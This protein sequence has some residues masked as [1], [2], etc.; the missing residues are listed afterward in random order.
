ME[1]HRDKGR[2][3]LTVTKRFSGQKGVFLFS[4]LLIG[5]TL[6]V[7][8][9]ILYFL[10]PV[11][12]SSNYYQKSLKPLRKQAREIKNEFAS[13]ISGIEQKQ[14]S[15]STLSFPSKRNE[16]FD[17]LKK[18]NINSDREG[19]SYYDSEGKLT[20]WLGKVIDLET[21]SPEKDTLKLFQKEKSSFLIKDKASVYLVFP[22]EVNSK[23][24]IVFNRL[25]AFEPQFKTRYLREYQFLKPKIQKN[26]HSLLYY[27]Y[28]EDIS[29]FERFFARHKDEYIGQPALQD[30]TQTLFFPLRNEKKKIMALVT[31]GSPSLAS[32]V[33][34]QKENILLSFYILFGTTLIFFLLYLIKSTAFYKDIKFLPFL[35]FILTLISLRLT[36]LSMSRLETINSLSVFSPSLASFLSSAQLTKSPAD[37]FLTA[38]FL[39][40][41]ISCVVIYTKNALQLSRNKLPFFLSFLLNIILIFFSI[42]ISL[43]FLKILKLFIYNSNINL[44]RYTFSPAFILLHLSILFLFLSFI[45]II[46]MAFRMIS[47]RSS[48][49]FLT[50]PIFVL[51]F[52]SFILFFEEKYSLLIVLFQTIV[53]FFLLSYAFFPHVLKR[54]NVFVSAFLLGTLFLYISLHDYSSKRSKSLVQNT[55]KNMVTSQEDWG[56]FLVSQSIPEIEERKESILSFIKS[57]EPSDFAQSL[58]SETSIAKFNWYSSLEIWNSEEKMISRFSLNIPELYPFDFDLPINQEWSIFDLRS[59]FMGK[60]KYFLVGYK[61]WF[62]RETHLGRVILTLSVDYDMLPFLYP[63]N[64]YFELIRVTSLPSLTQLDLGFIIFD[65]DGKLLFNPHG[66]STGISPVLLERIRSSQDSIWSSFKDKNKKYNA[67]YFR[68]KDRIYSFFMPKKNFINYSVEFLKLLFIYIIFFIIS[69]LLINIILARKKLK[70]P[71][72]SFSNKVYTSFIAIAIISLLIFAFFTRNFLERI[73]AQQYIEKAETH[74]NFAYRVMEDFIF[75]HQP[76]KYTPVA[77]PEDL[78]LWISSTINNDVNLYKEGKVYASSRREFYD[79]GLLP[80]LIDGEIY[81]EIQFENNPFT[82]QIQKIGEYSLHTL[83]IPFF[84]LDSF[85]L[86][87]LPF[88]FEQQ[89]ISKATGGFFEFLVFISLFFIIIVLLFA[90][91]LGAIIITPI[92]K[93]LAG[94]KEVSLGNLEVSIEHKPQDEMRTLIDGFNTMIKNLKKHQQELTEMSKTVAWAEMARKVAHE[95]K[96]PLTPIQLSAE[97]LLKVY[98][99]KKGD[100]DKALKESASYI[101]KEVENLKKIAHEFL[102]ASK[103]EPLKVKPFDLREVI[104]ET[105]SPYEKMLLERIKFKETYEGQDFG[106]KGDKDKIR[107]ALRNIFINAIEAIRNKGE[108]EVK[109]K[110][111]PKNLILEIRDTGMGMEK[112]MLKKAFEPYFSTKDAGTGLG[113]SIAKKIID[114]HGGSIQIS[115]QLSKGTKVIIKFPLA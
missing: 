68:T 16:I 86:I 94:T 30:K 83:T 27:D 50:L 58:W 103:E 76:E 109:L 11:F 115:S 85:L 105:A 73:F 72:W 12:I 44:L 48:R 33:S 37:I 61:D 67:F 25:L 52:G 107:I 45:L 110:R 18:S 42:L 114:E 5:I 95:I 51:G 108:I 54:K 2:K 60:E 1:N 111:V 15:I 112:F 9:L 70:N 47:L 71:L 84:F 80:E 35:L 38:F 101:I 90:R 34:T 20:L 104:Q 26:L 96:N 53:V 63:A 100:F 99:D 7:F 32:F 89:E 19:I 10:L 59:L 75:R 31:L 98:T 49:F 81:Y 41:I 64:P 28:R 43:A 91:G 113:L 106:F 40:S 21:F 23:G 46:Y 24:Y 14:I 56:D 57:P 22:Q 6:S 36:L 87:S 8:T 55:L 79:S 69:S 74:A 97:H 88:P 39:L 77:P 82:T 65:L 66:L 93:L 102:E 62:D 3:I 17:L 13:I 78:V 29:G 4:G 92:K